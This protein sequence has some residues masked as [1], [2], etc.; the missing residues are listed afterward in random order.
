[1]EGTESELSDEK[2]GRRFA[3][4]NEF[5]AKFD[6]MR[7]KRAICVHAPTGTL[8]RFQHRNLFAHFDQI[9]SGSKTCHAC[10]DNEGSH[11]TPAYANWFSLLRFPSLAYLQGKVN[12]LQAKNY[13]KYE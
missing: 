5:R 1:V 12:T 8:A 6:W 4:M 7:G 11:K 13:M 9:T 10:A 3:A 2:S